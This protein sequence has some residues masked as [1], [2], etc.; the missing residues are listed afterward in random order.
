MQEAELLLLLHLRGVPVLQLV[1]TADQ[2]PL[3]WQVELIR[4]KP[5]LHTPKQIWPGS[6]PLQLP[7]LMPSALGTPLQFTATVTTAN[8]TAQCEMSIIQFGASWSNVSAVEQPL[9]QYERWC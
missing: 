7:H 6:K 1:V 3:V 8:K 9:P 5:V 4:P 2:L